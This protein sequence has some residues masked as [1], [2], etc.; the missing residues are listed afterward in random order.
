MYR[1][2]N[3][4]SLFTLG[5]TNGGKT[6]TVLGS[7]F[8]KKMDNNST[9]VLNNDWGI[10][11]RSLDHIIAR[12]NA[13]NAEATSGPRLQVYLSYLDIYNEGIYDVT[14]EGI[15]ICQEEWQSSCKDC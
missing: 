7:G 15:V 10:I 1:W 2:E 13:M 4:H 11:P 12:V 3:R 6:H 5:V 9:N 8:E 14:Q